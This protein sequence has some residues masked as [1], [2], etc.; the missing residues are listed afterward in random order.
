M[1]K[2]P[3][4][5]SLAPM[6]FVLS[7][8]TAFSV[9]AQ[10]LPPQCRNVVT[11]GQGILDGLR[12][13]PQGLRAYI[14]QERPDDAMSYFDVVGSYI[15]A[16]DEIEC[17]YMHAVREVR[18]FVPSALACDELFTRLARSLPEPLLDPLKIYPLAFSY[19]VLLEVE[20]SHGCRSLAPAA[21]QRLDAELLVRIKAVVDAL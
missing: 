19:A 16:W 6:I 8:F 7:L 9:S 4:M 14:A 17:T 20:A 2:F 15:D 3:C 21:G 18:G 1:G 10:P 5:K 13:D 11:L 12:S